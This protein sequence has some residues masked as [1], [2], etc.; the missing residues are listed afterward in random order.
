[1]KPKKRFVLPL[2]AVLVLIGLAILGLAL[3]SRRAP[4]DL[5]P[6]DGALRPCPPSPNCVCSQEARAEASVEP[7]RFGAE[8]EPEA[9]FEA[10][11]AVIADEPSAELAK[12]DGD[13]AHAVWSTPLLGF[14]DDV[15]LLL[16]RE[17]RA[18]HVRSASRVG[19]SDLGAN[20]ERVDALRAAFEAKLA[21]AR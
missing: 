2:L 5:G 14:R 9:A 20:L 4:E 17:A 1:M 8:V 16:D 12:R 13:Y 11:L 18:I 21:A 15:E 7:L 3:A 6:V 19:H 10:L